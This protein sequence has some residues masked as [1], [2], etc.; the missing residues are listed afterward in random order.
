MNYDALFSFAVFAE[1]LNFTRAATRLALSQPALHVKIRKLAE[2]LGRPLYRKQGRALLLTAEGVKLAAYAR[3][4][5]D[6]GQAVLEE[7]RGGS[8]TGPVVLAAGEGAFLYL[9]GPAL[10]RFPK[11]RWPLRLL[12]LRGPETLEAVASARAHVGVVAGAQRPEELESR[13]LCE[14]GQKVVVPAG[15]RLARRRHVAPRDLGGEPLIVVPAGL[16]HRAML[17]QALAADG[18][19][20]M[21]AVEA[22][23][24]ELMLHFA[25]CGMG[26]AV[27]NDF[28]PAP[29]GMVGVPL[30]G[31]PTVT[32]WLVRRQAMR[33]PGAEALWALLGEERA[34][35]G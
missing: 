24:W 29:R 31:V 32:Y 34:E 19:R 21:V 15:H 4:V 5:R 20:L 8:Q 27:V 14:V 10:R 12:T 25:R 13:A 11:E 16:P 30:T 28:C 23:G 33:T 17:E 7:L 35:R 1:E 22:T 6:R 3:E 2:E 18:A 9:L 26:L